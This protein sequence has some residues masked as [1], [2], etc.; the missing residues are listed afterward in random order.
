[1]SA[2]EIGEEMA[3]RRG[4]LMLFCV[5]LNIREIVLL[6]HLQL[7]KLCE[8][9]VVSGWRKQS[10]CVLIADVNVLCQP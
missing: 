2:W 3:T 5:T 10:A 7:I 8:P 6:C 4:V 9:I 1:M